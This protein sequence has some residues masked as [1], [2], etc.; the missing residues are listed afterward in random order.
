LAESVSIE[1]VLDYRSGREG[2]L[3][4]LQPTHRGGRGLVAGPLAEH[5][6]DAKLLAGV[7]VLRA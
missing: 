6:V 3:Q 2:H 7:T 1:L 4:S 5:A